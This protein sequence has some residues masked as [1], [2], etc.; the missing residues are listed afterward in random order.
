MTGQEQHPDSPQENPP[1]QPTFISLRWRL[2]LPLA[3]VVT[4]VAMVGAYVLAGNLA[5]GIRVSEDNLLLQGSLAVSGRAVSLFD[6]QRAEARRAAFTVGVAPAIRAGQSTSLHAMLEDMARAAN[7]DSIIVTDA[8]GIEVT[9]LLRAVTSTFTD[10][11]VSTGT[12]LSDQPIVQ[13]VLL[14][15]VIGAT[16]LLRTPEGLLLYTGVPVELDGERVGALL[17]GLHMERV[18]QALRSSAVAEVMLYDAS[19]TLLQSTMPLDAEA[20]A[21]L[22]L[23]RGVLNQTLSTVGQVTV[24]PS[25]EVNGVPYRIA[26]APFQY[27]ENVLGVTATLL[28]DTVPFATAIGRQLTALLAAALVGAVVVG[29]FVGL[30]YVLVRMRRV[31]AVVEALAIGQGYARTGMQATD[32]IGQMGQ[33][34]DRYADTVQQHR[35]RLRNMLRRQRR[36]TAYLVSVLESMPDGVIVQDMEGRAILMNETARV[37]L[38]P[39][40]TPHGLLQ[41]LPVGAGQ[42]GQVLA[43][44]FYALGDPQRIDLD[45]RVISAQA[46]AVA[47]ASDVRLGTVV[48][49]RDITQHVREEQAR[50]L[51]LDR[52]AQD[53]Q[54]PLGTL[55]RT[56]AG[57]P[58]MLVNAFARE[59]GRYSAA[60]QKMIVEMRELTAYN[61]QQARRAQ[62]PLRVETLIWALYND[63]RQIAQA[64]GLGLNVIIE[65]KGLYVL[66]DEGRLRWALGNVV[67]NAVKYTP[68]GGVMTLEIKGE[69]EGMAFLRV[70]DSGVG[71]LREELDHIFTRFY[72]GTPTMDDGQ[73]IRVPGMGQ[74]LSIAKQI[75]EAHAGRIH[76]KSKPGV[77]TAVYI[78]LPLTAPVSYE[79]PL[80]A[81]ELM[82]GETLPLPE[83]V[84][85][86]AFWNLKHP[87][88]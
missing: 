49:L 6:E 36:E 20:L 46:A 63:W 7:L 71:I 16:G 59:V 45:G 40:R 8:Q 56:G 5:G 75:F 22:A 1:P 30:S 62:R 66:G 76:I 24:A 52:L 60:L 82:E 42:M 33:A 10:Y 55:S 61:E 3:A 70:R 4:I 51:L 44:G 12:D 18:L 27:G 81:E 79:L 2:L 83:D 87:G 85:L 73:V 21:V 64:A 54:Q 88:R 15:D 9:G 77:G 14:S 23:D 68:S 84:D 78:G 17:V 26:Y 53:I 25:R 58:N 37:L 35:D 57:S 11:A 80:L 74:G 38:G 69:H 65:A 19:G 32:E 50:D 47:T 48:V 28:T 13:D 41:G 29:L 43:P 86:D 67:D 39:E 72:R 31:T 34:L